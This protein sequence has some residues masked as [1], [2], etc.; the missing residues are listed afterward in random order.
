MKRI[1]TL[2]TLAGVSLSVQ[3]QK[4]VID[5]DASPALAFYATKEWQQAFMGYYGVESGTEPGLPEDETERQV[6]GQIRDFLQ[7]GRDA[8]VAAAT[9]AIANL[10]QQQRAAG[11]NTSPM[12]LQIA[13]TLEMRNAEITK[14]PAQVKR[15]QQR[16]Q[17][18]LKQ[19]VSPE[20]GF[21]NFLRAHKNLA[22]LL[23]RTD[24]PNEAVEHFV[25]AIQLGD[26]DAV[27]YG[28]LGAIYMDQG[29]LISSE[30]SLRNSIM[31]NPGISQFQQLL[32]NVL[33]MQEGFSEA[34]EIFARLLAKNPN[35]PNF[36]MAQA[37]CY[38]A[39]DEI[40]KAARNLEIVRF[41]YKANAASLMLLGDVYMNKEM[42]N[43]ATE[44]YLDAISSEPSKS[45]LPRFL[46]SA[47]TLNNFAAYDNGMKV[48]Q[49]VA[50]AYR[51]QLDDEEEI[52]LLSLSSEINISLGKGEEA[53]RNLEA[54]LKKDPFN[55]RALLSL[56]RYYSNLEPDDSLPDEQYT[57]LKHRN[58]QTAILYY[59]RAERLQDEEDLEARVRAY[60]G[61]AQLRVRRRELDKAADLLIE[62]QTL[63]YQDNIQDYLEQIQ[64]ALKFRRNS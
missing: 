7:T 2:I 40:S 5:V 47:E 44:A 63:K 27:T 60:I 3:A 29:K 1:I 55:A 6:L 52:N 48:I 15:M 28:I 4:S 9:A 26:R 34:K 10:M 8:D 57:L 11:T 24:Q 61:E 58:E 31:M 64:E 53:A 14:D 42:V 46:Q 43:E 50:Q 21:P 51:G 17:A 41:M 45:N 13:G 16:A 25:K 35:E 30:T 62:A 49:A 38:I 32:G 54:L 12:M 56:A 33:L 22:N 37:N 39:L 59:E 20:T 18:Y 23:F 36:W 19:A